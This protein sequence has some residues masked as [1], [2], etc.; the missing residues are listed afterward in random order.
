MGGEGV[1]VK[2]GHFE[3]IVITILIILLVSQQLSKYCTKY[4]II[5]NWQLSENN[6]MKIIRLKPVLLT[7]GVEALG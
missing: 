2:S 5:V 6:K 3:T 7:R 1:R 4:R